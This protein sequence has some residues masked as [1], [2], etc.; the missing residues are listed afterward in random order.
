MEG[1]VKNLV[2]FYFRKFFYNFTKE[3]NMKKSLAWLTLLCVAIF[4][5]EPAPVAEPAA[6][7][8]PVSAPPAVPKMSLAEALGSTSL[9]ASCKEDFTS[10]LGKDGFSMGS[11]M[12]D[13]PVAVAKVKV[14]MKA[15]FGKPK[16]SDKTSAGVTVACIKSLPENPAD[17]GSLLADIGM[18]AG[19][20]MA[21]GA[22]DG[23]IP[24][25]I[26]NEGGSGGGS[27]VAKIVISS[28]MMASGLGLGVYGITLNGDV[29]DNVS[30][31]KGKAAMDA[32]LSRDMFYGIGG[33]LLGSGLIVL[34]AF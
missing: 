1:R 20:S 12:K 26:P 25:N 4:A 15:P 3:D 24:T 5:Q 33:A 32:A 8:A 19:L 9:S 10:V 17:I 18:K 23:S 7:P 13:L 2:F 27:K 31:G 29:K 28:L 34:I 11:F 21:A 30:K 22:G 6:A 14:Q 16:D